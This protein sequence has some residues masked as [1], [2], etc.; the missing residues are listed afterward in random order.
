MERGGCSQDPALQNMHSVIELYALLVYQYYVVRNV[1]LSLT[2]LPLQV[3]GW[4]FGL[5]AQVG[6]T[7]RGQQSITED[8]CNL[9]T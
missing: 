3:G 9:P 8:F 4:P 7:T 1:H 6:F 2:V 5:I